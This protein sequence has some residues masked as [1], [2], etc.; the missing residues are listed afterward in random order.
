MPTPSPQGNRMNVPTRTT[1]T[2]SPDKGRAGEGFGRCGT[3]H[4]PPLDPPL[5]R[6]EAVLPR[7]P[8]R[9]FM[10]LPWPSP[11]TSEGVGEQPV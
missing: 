3:T 9:G 1:V 6:G 10:Q 4:N 5:V 11:K 2:P 7:T 8:E